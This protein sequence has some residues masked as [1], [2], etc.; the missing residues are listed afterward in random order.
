MW[1]KTVGWIHLAE[2]MNTSRAVIDTVIKLRFD[3]GE[4]ILTS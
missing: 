4:D 1:C 2:D 3:T